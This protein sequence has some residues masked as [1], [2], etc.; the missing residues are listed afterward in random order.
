MRRTQMS[1]YS[2][3]QLAGVLCPE[4][5]CIPVKK[6]RTY[7]LPSCLYNPAP[8][9]QFL[10]HHILAIVFKAEGTF[11]TKRASSSVQLYYTGPTFSA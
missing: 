6:T 2:S 3:L 11:K 7:I 4:T 10:R 8:L 9:A 5:L 1:F